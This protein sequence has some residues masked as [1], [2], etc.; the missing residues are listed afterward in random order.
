MTDKGIEMLKGLPQLEELSLDSTDVSDLGAEMLSAMPTLKS[1]D[2]YHTLIS[3]KGYQRIK[4]SLPGCRI[5]W[6]KD[7]ALPSRRH[8]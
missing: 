4:S 2:L 5:F 8:L 6:E 7:S 1:L 3:D